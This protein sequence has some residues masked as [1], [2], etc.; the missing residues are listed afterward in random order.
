MKKK[1]IGIDKSNGKD[2]SVEVK[3]FSKK[4]IY[5]IKSIKTIK[6]EKIN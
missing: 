2:K 3:F 4:G 5:Y 6:D 1:F